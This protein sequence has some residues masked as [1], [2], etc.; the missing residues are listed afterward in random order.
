MKTKRVNEANIAA[1]A[2]QIGG[3]LLDHAYPLD[4]C[5]YLC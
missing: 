5:T 3:L 1:V 2:D 4:T